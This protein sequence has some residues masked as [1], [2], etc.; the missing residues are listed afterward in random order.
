MRQPTQPRGEAIPVPPFLDP[1]QLMVLAS[2]N[3]GK[4]S[5]MSTESTQA[6]VT[7]F[8]ESD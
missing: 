3:H 1:G 8:S 7:V 4:A 6:E 2:P 5:V